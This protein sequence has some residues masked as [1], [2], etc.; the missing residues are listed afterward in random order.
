[1]KEVKGNIW[2]FLPAPIVIP[3]NQGWKKDSTNVMGKGLAR[4]AAERYPSLPLLLGTYCKERKF[5]ATTWPV[6]VY[7][8]VTGEVQLLLCFP[9]KPLMPQ[10]PQ[11]SWHGKASVALVKKSL[12]T[13]ALLASTDPRLIREEAI[14]LPLV[15]CGEGELEEETVL[16]LL[17]EALSDKFVLVRHPS[18]GVRRPTPLEWKGPSI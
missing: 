9:T 6:E 13:L 8:H 4:Q 17:Q 1:M 15:G 10:A 12:A 11:F 18:S 2:Q 14:Y 7:S 3:T 16:P 5:Y